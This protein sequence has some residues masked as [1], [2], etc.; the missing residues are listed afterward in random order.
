MTTDPVPLSTAQVAVIRECHRPVD[1][2]RR[3]E[4]E[5]CGN[6]WP[7]DAAQLVATLDEA[8]ATP[9]GDHKR[10]PHRDEWAVGDWHCRCGWW[11]NLGWQ[12]Y[13]DHLEAALRSVSADSTAG[14][15]EAYELAQAA[16]QLEYERAVRAES[17]LTRERLEAAGFDTPNDNVC[18]SCGHAGGDHDLGN[19]CLLCPRP[20]DWDRTAK[21]P[22][23]AKSAAGWCFFA[24]MTT[25]Q[26]WDRALAALSP[27]TPPEPEP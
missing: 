19:W 22:T 10:L 24:S 14:L 25:E 16:R 27:S 6:V 3:T 15:R 8:R 20:D 21:S 5:C 17:A 7:C 23:G 4:C 11:G 18:A 2:S 9:S 12:G 26:R 13:A 1:S